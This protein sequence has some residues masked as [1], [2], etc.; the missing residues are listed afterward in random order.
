MKVYPVITVPGG[1]FIIIDGFLVRL[2]KR[3]LG[4]LSSG[5]AISLFTVGGLYTLRNFYNPN[6]LLKMQHMKSNYFLTSHSMLFQLMNNKTYIIFVKKKDRY[7]CRKTE[8]GRATHI[9]F[10][11]KIKRV[12]GGFRSKYVV[13][14][15]PLTSYSYDASG[16]Y[17]Q[18]HGDL[19]HIKQCSIKHDPPLKSSSVEEFKALDVLLISEEELQKMT[20]L[21]ITKAKIEW[22]AMNEEEKRILKV[23]ELMKSL[24][25]LCFENSLWKLE[26]LKEALRSDESMMKKYEDLERIF[27]ACAC[28]ISKNLQ[29]ITKQVFPDLIKRWL[30]ESEYRKCREEK[31]SER[32]L[33]MER[34]LVDLKNKAIIDPNGDDF[35]QNSKL[36]E[37]EKTSKCDLL[38]WDVLRL[39]EQ[40]FPVHSKE[41]F[42]IVDCTIKEFFEDSRG[43]N[44]MK[45]GN[46]FLMKSEKYRCISLNLKNAGNRYIY[47]KLGSSIWNQTQIGIGTEMEDEGSPW[48]NPPMKSIDKECRYL[49][50]KLY[51][52]SSY[53]EQ[54]KL[55]VKSFNRVKEMYEAE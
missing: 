40:P 55:Y 54:R 5:E 23:E 20:T 22:I 38:D 46:E 26:K 19:K 39:S 28:N 42:E 35:I 33:I 32:Y 8:K 4:D 7:Y 15:T 13:F 14:D 43:V 16:I 17:E 50:E 49:F 1:Q 41:L 47:E 9:A 24:L 45:E 2:D 53:H 37:R 25:K 3:R 44:H 11:I 51:L 21:P 12:K 6:S 27:A 48:R 18:Q 10:H 29:L 34:F 30:K 36:S 52:F 31:I